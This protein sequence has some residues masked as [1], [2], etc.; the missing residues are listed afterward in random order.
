VLYYLDRRSYRRGSGNPAVRRARTV[1][2][3]WSL[4]G[5]SRTGTLEGLHRCRR[6]QVRGTDRA[7]V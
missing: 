6:R 1:S 7:G 3:S 2:G 4:R 5:R